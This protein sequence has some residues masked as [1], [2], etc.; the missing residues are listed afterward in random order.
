MSTIVYNPFTDNLDYRGPA[1]GGGGAISTI[2]T[3]A[4]DGGGE[5]GIQSGDGSVVIT[6]ITNGV[7]LSVPASAALEAFSAYLSA[8]MTNV[9]GDATIVTILF[10]GVLTN[11][12]AAYNPATG[13]YTAPTTGLYCFN[14]TISFL[15]GSADTA[16]YL[17]I[18]DG[19]AFNVRAFDVATVFVS[20]G[21]NLVIQSATITIPMN[22]GDGMKISAVVNAN[23]PAGS[24]DVTIYGEA[25]G[26]YAITSLFSGFRIS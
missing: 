2:N 23:P 11:T 24:P 3:I 20:V 8:P 19:S 15:G 6:P 9:T 22:A 1:S 14:Q 17:G 7:D 25:P 26:S 21:A 4:P 18:W 16:N 13:I 12:S 5:F 10:D